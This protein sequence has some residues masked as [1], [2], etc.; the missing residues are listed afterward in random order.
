MDEK[1]FEAMLSK[2]SFDAG[3][4][5]CG[6]IQFTEVH[7]VNDSVFKEPS[8]RIINLID[9][10][11]RKRR[12]LERDSTT[13]PANTI[14]VFG[15]ESQYEGDQ[16]HEILVKNRLSRYKKKKELKLLK[17]CFSQ[18]RRV[19]YGP[20]YVFKGNRPKPLTRDMV[21]AMLTADL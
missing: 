14:Q 21:F 19:T 2:W 20:G 16:L 13:P 15:P 5:T 12:Y 10:K 8:R 6:V 7:A 3:L 9:A 1:A 11:H 4:I 18:W 17:K